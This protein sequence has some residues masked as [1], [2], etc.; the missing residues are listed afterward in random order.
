[1]ETKFVGVRLPP[2]LYGQ[3]EARALREHRSMNGQ[4]LTYIELGLLIDAGTISSVELAVLSD[5]VV[6]EAIEAARS[7][8]RSQLKPRLA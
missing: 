3:L 8:D 6:R 7:R 5:P 1:M 2:D 4:A